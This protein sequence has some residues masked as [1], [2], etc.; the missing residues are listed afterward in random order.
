MNDHDTNNTD[1]CSGRGVEAV[2][3]NVEDALDNIRPH[4]WDHSCIICTDSHTTC[5]TL[6]NHIR[7]LEHRLEQHHNKTTHSDTATPATGAGHSRQNTTTT[8]NRTN[9]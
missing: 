9:G 7:D 2:I 6:I 5:R 3:A 4:H 1:A 8:S